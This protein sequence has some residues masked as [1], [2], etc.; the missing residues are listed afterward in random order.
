MQ[1]KP[2]HGMYL[3]SQKS[4]GKAAFTARAAADAAGRENTKP[5]QRPTET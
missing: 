5:L 2:L 1:W 4:F 3:M